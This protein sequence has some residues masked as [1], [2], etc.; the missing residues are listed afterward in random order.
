M[1]ATQK[2]KQKSETK[3]VQSIAFC[4]ANLGVFEDVECQIFKSSVLMKLL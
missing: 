4:V 3:I 2:V 1:M